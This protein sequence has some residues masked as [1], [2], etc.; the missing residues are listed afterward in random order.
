MQGQTTDDD[1]SLHSNDQLLGDL[2]MADMESGRTGGGSSIEGSDA[3]E[4]SMNST[5]NKGKNKGNT[6][7]T[8]DEAYDVD[9]L[10]EDDD[11][12]DAAELSWKDLKVTSPDG[13][14]VLLSEACGRVKGRFL[15]IMGPSGAGKTSLMNMLACRLA[16][17]KGKGDQMVDGQK[18]NRSFLKKVSGY[19]MQDDLLFPDL[20]VKETLRYAAFLRLPAKMSRDEKLKRVDEVIVKIG[21]EHCKNTPVG[22]ALKKGLSG[23]ERKRLCVAMELLMKPRLLFLDEPTSGLDGVTALTLC[24]ILRD[25]AH[26]ENCT[27]VCTIHQP[28]TQI[29]N[30]FDDLM[31]LKSGKIV[32]HGPAD[33]VVNHYAEAGFPCPVHTNPADHVLDVISPAK[34]TE[35]EIKEADENADKIRLLYT[36]PLVEDPPIK[37]D[38]R[39]KD[40]SLPSRPSWFSQV[41]YLFLRAMQNVMRARMVLFAQLVQTII[42]GILIGTVFLDIGTNQEG[43]KKRLSVLFFICINQGVFSALILI[44]SFPSERLI[45]LRERASGAYY[46]SAYYVAKMMAE[47]TVQMFFPLLFSCIVYFLVGFQ[48]DAG[49]F[50]I[51]VCFMEL[52]SLTATSLALMISTFCRTVTLSITILPLILEICR[53]YGGFFLPPSKLPA[54]FS[55]LDALSFV[56]Y[57][58]TGIALNELNGLKL[59]CEENEL[60]GGKCPITSG[61]QVIKSNGFDYITIWGCALVLI[62][63]II[64]FRILAFVGL[65]WV[66]G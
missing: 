9:G 13:K 43:Q 48:N 15:A 33:E 26:S 21:L 24:R 2:E 64:F 6:S 29:F 60:V 39:K 1:R 34:F 49:K 17:A 36:P 28:A 25:L 51:F 55:W 58:Y 32:Y 10:D 37:K 38:K 56:K 52:C 7:G 57:S 62:A 47:M 23:G 40:K 19:V 27:V 53:L 18:Y 46:V 54:Y 11:Y 4:M 35:D 44:N 50:F 16:K 61:E 8:D 42:F 30:L 41:W 31:I 12:G 22:S 66:K 14:K 63:M 59:Y 20:T 3:D 5:K 65:R 45:V